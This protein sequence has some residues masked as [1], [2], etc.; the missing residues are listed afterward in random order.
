MIPLFTS[1][2]PRISRQ[3]PDGSEIGREYAQQCIAS[4]RKSGFHP[5]TLNAGDEAVSELVQSEG[6]ERLSMPQNARERFGRPLVYLDDFIR[7][8][9]ARTDGVVAIVNS[10]I[11]L[12]MEPEMFGQLPA[13]QPGY[14]LFS[15]R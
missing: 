5:I 2:P 10:D 13:L 3:A 8:A 15:K 6:I 4:W 12:D 9:R 7:V 1:I 14:G 11:L